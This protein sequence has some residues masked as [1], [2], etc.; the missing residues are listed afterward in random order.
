MLVEPLLGTERPGH[1]VWNASRQSDKRSSGRSPSARSAQTTIA[2]V[3]V[4]STGFYCVS[5]AVRTFL[6]LPQGAAVIQTPCP[7]RQHDSSSQYL[8]PTR[9]CARTITKHPF[10]PAT[11]T[12]R[13][14]LHRFGRGSPCLLDIG[15]NSAH[16]MLPGLRGRHSMLGCAMVQRPQ[17]S[18]ADARSARRKRR[19]HKPGASPL[20]FVAPQHS[21]RGVSA[22]LAAA[23]TPFAECRGAGSGACGYWRCPSHSRS[24]PSDCFCPAG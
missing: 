7:L 21:A 13:P 9:C 18:A 11:V 20:G 4:L 8:T 5:T 1:G 23:S 12:R 16:S 22:A 14:Y 3:T 10:E 17:L 2:I 6:L 24:R 15:A 19:Q